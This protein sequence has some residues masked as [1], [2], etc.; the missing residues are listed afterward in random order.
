M[1][2]FNNMNGRSEPIIQMIHF[3]Y[4]IFEHNKRIFNNNDI[5]LT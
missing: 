4:Y 1:D 3:D 2:W 5:G